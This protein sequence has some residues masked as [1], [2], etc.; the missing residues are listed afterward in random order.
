RRGVGE[1]QGVRELKVIESKGNE[2]K[3]SVSYEGS[4]QQFTDLLKQTDFQLFAVSIREAAQNRIKLEL[5][6]KP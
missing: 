5:M 4:F 2:A 6:P 1:F 3:L